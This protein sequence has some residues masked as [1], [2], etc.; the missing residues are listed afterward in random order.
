[1]AHRAQLGGVFGS[2]LYPQQRNGGQAAEVI[3]A[4]TR[5]AT[6][7]IQGAY[8]RA[9]KDR[10]QKLQDQ[11]LARRDRA[12]Q[13]DVE[14][15]TF[16]RGMAVRKESRE[17]EA[18]QRADA[19]A[20]YTPPRIETKD[21]VE[22]GS[23]ETNGAFGAPG[24]VTAPKIKQQKLTIPGALDYTKSN[25]YRARAQ[26]HDIKETERG[27]HITDSETIHE[28]NRK[29]D[30]ANPMPSRSSSGSTS[31]ASS[32]AV[33]AATSVRA[34]VA[35][36]TGRIKMLETKRKNLAPGVIPG[37]DKTAAA[38]DQQLAPLIARRDSLTTVGD[39]LAGQLTDNAGVPRTI[40]SAYAGK[41]AKPDGSTVREGGGQSPIKRDGSTVRT[42]SKPT[43]TQAEAKSLRDRGFT[44]K[45][46]ATKYL[47]Q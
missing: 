25:A 2:G 42:G 47:I 27:E 1:M 12:E 3:D 46:I 30:V 45:Q 35:D 43:I 31:A 24:K 18:Q 16:D 33:H 20:G 6:T 9:Q 21:V 5:G 34:Q 13:R 15:D 7:L 41:T 39:R 8:A 11:E 14:K 40:K 29:V 23:V 22:P 32:A 26:T 10:E 28:H 38:I 19:A 37:D 36:A 4:V 17:A 44:D